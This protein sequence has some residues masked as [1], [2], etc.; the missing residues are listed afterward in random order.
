MYDPALARWNVADPAKELYWNHSPYNYA[1]NNP[2][3]A[4]DPDGNIVIFINGFAMD[5]EQKGTSKYWEGFDEAVTWKLNDENRIYRHGGTSL[6]AM[7]RYK[8][9]YEQAMADADYIISQVIDENGNAKETIKIITHSMGGAYG[10]GYLNA[11]KTYLRS[12]GYH[13]AM[14]TLV[15]DFDPYQASELSADPL[16]YTQQHTHKKKGEGNYSRLANE[17][18]EGIED[19]DYHEDESKGSHDITSFFGNVFLLKE[20][21]YVYRNG[22]WVFEEIK[23]E[24]K[25]DE[26]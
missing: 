23:K 21:T 6:N 5:K 14:I 20:G 12:K 25:K 10:K 9:G 3:N 4:I 19:E 16:I 13:N 1:L 15:A 24:K 7:A 26:K 11:L 8:D 2:I 18:Q 17:R 22:A